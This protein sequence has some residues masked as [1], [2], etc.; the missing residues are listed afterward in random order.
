MCEAKMP[1]IAKAAKDEQGRNYETA[2][3]PADMLSHI[4]DHG[5]GEAIGT[6]V[7]LPYHESSK[8]SR[9]G[10]PKTHLQPQL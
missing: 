6:S 8:V 10:I 3:P 4:C 9:F 2:C 7:I 1:A 5:D